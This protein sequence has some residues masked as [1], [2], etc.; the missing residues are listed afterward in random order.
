MKINALI[1]D[2]E[3][4][5]R[6]LIREF[7]KGHPSIADVEECADGFEGVKAIQERKPDLVFLDIQM[8]KINGL[9]ML[10]ILE[11]DLLPSVIFV[12]AHDEYALRAFEVNAVDYLLKPVARERFDMAVQ[13]A[14]SRIQAGSGNQREVE[15]LVSMEVRGPR[16]L[17][18]LVVK[19]GGDI[20]II[21][22]EDVLCMEAQDDYVLICTEKDAFLKKKTLKYFEQRLDPSVFVRIH[23][24]FLVRVDAIQRIEPYSK[25]AF[26]AT[27]KNGR[28]ISVSK[29][30]Y[31]SLRKR[32]D[33]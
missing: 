10:E 20:H 6:A 29:Q 27:L 16:W 12:T 2:D 31:A 3:A 26:I 5:A 24:S 23:R 1:I 19:A 11:S 33:F 13:K 14:L 21:A 17:D 8:P 30:G 7:L 9:E 15:G 25:D 18:R 32:F 28:K 22:E 4:P